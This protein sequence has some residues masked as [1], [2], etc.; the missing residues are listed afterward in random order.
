MQNR[1]IVARTGCVLALA[2][3]L[4]GA[5]AGATTLVRASVEDLVAANQTVV[6]GE[7]VDVMSY[8]NADGTFILTDV[9]V[10]PWEV[11]KG[12]ADGDLIL[13]QMGGTVGDA[14]TLIV[15]GPE[16]IPGH[17][18]V[19]FVNEEDL[20]GADGVTTVRDH[21]QG[22]FDI[23]VAKDGKLRAISQANRHPLVP[24]RQ[25]SFD[26]PG[27]VEGLELDALVRSVADAARRLKNDKEEN[28]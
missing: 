17:S 14:T 19:L 6:L 18:Y 21:C 10:R 9:T 11:L 24:D 8:W 4:C 2:A 1:S 26:A 3:I 22:A 28:R 5:P 27:G 13:T 20:P 25:G 23:L 16:L 7:V 12:S 15:G